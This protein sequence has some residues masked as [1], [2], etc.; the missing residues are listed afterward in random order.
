MS[1]RAARFFQPSTC[2]WLDD[3]L[4]LNISTYP[5]SKKETF[6]PATCDFLYLVSSSFVQFVAGFLSCLATI[7][8]QQGEHVP[9]PGVA[10]QESTETT[11]MAEAPPRK[12][13]VHHAAWLRY[14]V[15]RNRLDSF[16]LWMP[17]SDYRL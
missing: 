13:T 4:K 12:H 14:A 9:E 5:E 17:E 8:G 3:L 10:T 6:P 16:S 15:H 2:E 1:L 7:H 11:A